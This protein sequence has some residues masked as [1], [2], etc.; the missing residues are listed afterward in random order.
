MR[1]INVG[2]KQGFCFE[3]FNEPAIPKYAILSHTW[4]KQELSYAEASAIFLTRIVPYTPRAGFEKLWRFADEARML[5][6]DYIW[7]DTCKSSVWLQIC[8]S[9]HIS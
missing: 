3:E 9:V 8:W 7:I 5:K 2:N 6:L 4:G 1:L